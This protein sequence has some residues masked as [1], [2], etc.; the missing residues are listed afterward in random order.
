MKTQKVAHA[1]NFEHDI[2][3]IGFGA[4]GI[5]EF[6]G[7]TDEKA[8]RNAI[9]TALDYGMNHIDTAD[10]YAFGDNEIFLGKVLNLMDIENRKKL[11]IASKAGIKRDRNDPTVRGVCIEPEYL[12]K[13]LERSLK[14]L[15]TSYLDIFY[16][17]RLPPDASERELETLALFLLDIKVKGLAKSIGLSEPSLDQLKKIHMICPISFVQSEYNLLERGIEK[18]GILNFCRTNI[19][20][21]VAY[22]P[23][24]RGLLTEQF[25]V[26]QLDSA[27]FRASLPKFTGEN[28]ESNTNIVNKLK[29]FADNRKISLSCLAL[30]WL[31]A[32]NVLVIPGM[33]KPERVLD[34]LASLQF[35]L[36]TND[37]AMIDEI[38]YVGATMGTRYTEGAM[39]AYGFKH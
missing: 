15:G 39:K 20:N 5:S 1:S 23:L 21:F 8:A 22:S 38:A 3:V 9:K 31:R 33:R 16:I 2:P 13:Q 17:H 29:A 7:T 37:L 14:N 26:S 32:Q 6:Y 35:E 24:C 4:M 28:Y 11:I 27:D 10:G 12:R 30:A 19:I 25:N 18:T 34:A 36:T